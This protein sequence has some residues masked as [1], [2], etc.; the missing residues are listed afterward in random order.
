M[1][2]IRYTAWDGT[3]RIRLDPEE[4]FEKLAEVL[5]DTDDVRQALEWLLRQGLEIDGVEVMGLDELLEMLRSELRSR[6]ERFNLRHALDEP[7]QRLQEILERERQ[8]LNE[9]ASRPEAEALA[10][11]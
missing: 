1:I 6:E 10:R 11:E 8:T 2:R 4:V 5:S 3:Q 7:Q 9:M